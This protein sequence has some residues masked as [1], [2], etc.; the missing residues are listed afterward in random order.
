MHMKVLDSIYPLVF[1]LNENF[2]YNLSQ[3]LK[4]DQFYRVNLKEKSKKK[5]R[6]K[7][8]KK[9]EMQRIN[10]IEKRDHD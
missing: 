1:I 7:E 3:K 4:E 5:E 2:V 6:K 9:E 10:C 8:R